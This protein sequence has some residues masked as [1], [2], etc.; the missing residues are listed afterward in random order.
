L[1]VGESVL[2]VGLNASYSSTLA[3]DERASLEGGMKPA[4]YQRGGQGAQ[5]GFSVAPCSLGSLLVATTA[6]GLCSVA[7]G[8]SEEQLVADLHQAFSAADIEPDDARLQTQ[9][10]VLLAHLVGENPN[11]DLPVD[12]PATAFQWRVWHI[13]RSIGYGETRSYSQIAAILGQPQAVRAV[14]RAC[15]TNPVALVV[16]CHRVVR[17]DGSLGGFRWGLERKQSLLA[18]ERQYAA[19][20]GVG[21]S[22]QKLQ[23]F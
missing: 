8:G 18:Q 11:L 15:A 14:A 17:S 20:C 6:K 19:R 4:T 7:L 16:P 23:Q 10:E 5:I 1:Q 13:L 12:V 9:I 3:L 21:R 2:S 22:L